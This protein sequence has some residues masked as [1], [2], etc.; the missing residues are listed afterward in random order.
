MLLAEAA[1]CPHNPRVDTLFYA[2]GSVVT[3]VGGRVFDDPL[4]PEDWEE[5][6]FCSRFKV[7]ATR[8]PS[9]CGGASSAETEIGDGQSTGIRHGVVGEPF[10]NPPLSE[11]HRNPKGSSTDDDSD[12]RVGGP[13]PFAGTHHFDPNYCDEHDPEAAA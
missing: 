7:Y 2:D 6:G 1:S 3:I 4:T 9:D 5:L 12:G 13:T 11:S 10:S 8:R